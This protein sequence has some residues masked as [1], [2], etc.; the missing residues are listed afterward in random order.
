MKKLSCF[1]TMIFLTLNTFASEEESDYSI[2]Q[3]SMNL[4]AM[5][6]DGGY[7]LYNDSTGKIV[8]DHLYDKIYG[9]YAYSA[10]GNMVV[11]VR[12]GDRFGLIDAEN[13]QVILSPA[14][15]PITSFTDDIYAPEPLVWNIG[16]KKETLT[17]IPILI[18]AF[19][20][21]GN[22]LNP[23]WYYYRKGG[24]M[25]EPRTYM[26]IGFQNREGK[27]VIPPL[28][29]GRGGF[30]DGVAIVT[31][32][33]K[34][35]AISSISRKEIIPCEY[36]LIRYT[37]EFLNV[38]KLVSPF[39]Y[40]KGEFLSDPGGADAIEYAHTFEGLFDR[41]GKIIIPCEYGDIKLIRYEMPGD[42]AIVTQFIVRK[43]VYDTINRYLSCK[44]G[45]M[46]I[47]GNEIIPVKY[48]F[49][50]YDQFG[51]YV[52]ENSHE[53]RG[54]AEN[55]GKI[56]IPVK[57]KFIDHDQFGRYIILWNSHK[58]AGMAE[59]NGK[60]IIPIKYTNVYP[61][62]E[63]IIVELNGKCGIVTPRNKILIRPNKF[64]TIRLEQAHSKTFFFA[65]EGGKWGRIN[66]TGKILLEL[67][68]DEIM[69]YQEKDDN[70]MVVSF[71]GQ[72][73]R[74]DSSGNVME[75]YK[76]N[77]Y[78]IDEIFSPNVF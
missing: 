21:Y 23:V 42:T 25:N 34:A 40:A 43:D 55:N 53:L 63:Y 17:S 60:I 6:Q 27:E 15:S 46:D 11:V 30:A 29:D 20:G 38:Y 19:D 61:D 33:Y 45:V 10:W 2:I 47:N 76:K 12:S 67:K 78:E 35:G 50:Y 74:V 49:I 32:N 65:Q 37:G 51:R 70:S 1:I 75:Q 16:G 36:D 71:N 66:C 41:N 58:L 57:Y 39:Y 7:K 73:M 68:Y 62:A 64:E 5:K 28:Y 22:D 18:Y 4:L 26:R 48:S 31:K 52:L 14:D 69:P 56:I 8:S 54:L 13:G 24:D 44:Y 9:C 59:N 3:G 72:W 77:P